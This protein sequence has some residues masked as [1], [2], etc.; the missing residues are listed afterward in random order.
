[1]NRR[2]DSGLRL[3]LYLN[4]STPRPSWV[5]W[6]SRASSRLLLPVLSVANNQG[7]FT[8]MD[9]VGDDEGLIKLKSST[10]IVVVSIVVVDVDVHAVEKE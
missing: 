6:F 3:P 8:T 5:S 9:V 2:V 7:V 10:M 4:R 1:M